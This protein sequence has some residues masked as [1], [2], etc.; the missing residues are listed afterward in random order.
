MN[1][2]TRLLFSG[3]AKFGIKEETIRVFL[4]DGTEIDDDE[5]FKACASE[6]LFVFLS[7]GEE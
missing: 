5:T 6:T 3:K 4:Q 1:K 7:N 2:E